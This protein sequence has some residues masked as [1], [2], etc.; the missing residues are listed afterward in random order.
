MGAKRR[1]RSLIKLL[2]QTLTKLPNGAMENRAPF[3]SG[4]Q[5]TCHVRSAVTIILDL[6]LGV[7]SLARRWR[8]RACGPANPLV[9][10]LVYL[11]Q[12]PTRPDSQM[13]YSAICLVRA[14]P[15]DRGQNIARLRSSTVSRLRLTLT[16]EIKPCCRTTMSLKAAGPPI[17]EFIL[18]P[19]RNSDRSF[20][21]DNCVDRHIRSGKP[22]MPEAAGCVKSWPKGGPSLFANFSFGIEG[23][24]GDPGGTFCTEVAMEIRQISNDYS[25]TGQIAGRYK[26]TATPASKRDL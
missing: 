9:P 3:C 17:D 6:V 7:V 4:A 10:D 5:A 8:G 24:D 2:R 20:M 23:P 25:A 1:R 11:H 26:H 19:L 13:I 21:G 18:S 16:G 15:V 22:E 12:M 14:Y